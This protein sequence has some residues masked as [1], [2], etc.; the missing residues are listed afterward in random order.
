MSWWQILI[1]PFLHPA[2]PSTNSQSTPPSQTMLS[3]A[4]NRMVSV[5]VIKLSVSASTDVLLDKKDKTWQRR[6]NH[7]SDCSGMCTCV[8]MSMCAHVYAPKPCT[9]INNA[10]WREL[11]LN[12]PSPLDHVSGGSACP[13][14]KKICSWKQELNLEFLFLYYL[15]LIK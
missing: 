8:C 15:T 13:S 10:G 4:G 5:S 1:L 2:L 11:P 6:E 9:N 14:S 7:R 12:P 3:T